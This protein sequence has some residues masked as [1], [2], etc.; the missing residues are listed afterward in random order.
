MGIRIFSLFNKKSLLL[1]TYSILFIVFQFIN[2]LEH[3]SIFKK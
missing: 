1:L 2:I 3:D